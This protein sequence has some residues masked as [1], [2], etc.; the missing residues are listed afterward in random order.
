MTLVS[1]LFPPERQVPGVT[2]VLSNPDITDEERRTRLYS[3]QVRRATWRHRSLS[4]GR[5]RPQSHRRGVRNPNCIP[6]PRNTTCRSR[7]S[8][9]L[10]AESQ[11]NVIYDPSP[12]NGSRHCSHLLAVTSTEPTSTSRACLHRRPTTHLTSGISYAFHSDRDTWCSAP[13]RQPNWWIPIYPVVPENAMA[14]HPQYSALRRRTDRGATITTVEPD[15]PAQRRSAHQGRYARPAE[16][17]RTGATPS[18]GT[19]GARGGRSD[20]FFR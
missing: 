7:T 17:G 8:P 12:R 19:R 13:F 14:F 4:V 11:A 6:S 3:G 18:P 15:E 5:A 10:F 1:S 16:T 20:A 9:V 2:T